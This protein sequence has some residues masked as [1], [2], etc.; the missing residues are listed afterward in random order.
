MKRNS[1]TSQQRRHSTRGGSLMNQPEKKQKE[2]SKRL[3]DAPSSLRNGVTDC[4]N[5]NRIEFLLQEDNCFNRNRI[6]TS[7]F[8]L[9][10][11]N[12]NLLASSKKQRICHTSG[13]HFTMV[14]VMTKAQVSLLIILFVTLA[15]KYE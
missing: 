14:N 13:S 9:S 7:G 10:T 4:A 12:N 5:N 3:S 2:S 11:A 1:S 8:G 6:T 15:G